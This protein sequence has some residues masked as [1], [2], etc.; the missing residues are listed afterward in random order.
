MIYGEVGLRFQDR[1]DVERFSPVSTP[2][3]EV[4]ESKSEYESFQMRGLFGEIPGSSCE[5]IHVERWTTSD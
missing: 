4:V 5:P 3:A 1:L 2:I